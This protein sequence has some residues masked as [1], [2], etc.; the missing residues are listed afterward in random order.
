MLFSR[1]RRKKRSRA[2]AVDW[3]DP[4]YFASSNQAV[5]V[6]RVVW[7]LFVNPK[8][9]KTVPTKSGIV[10]MLLMGGLGSAAY[11]TAS[12]IL[13]LTVALLAAC[14]VLSGL[15]SWLNFKGTRWRLLPPNH[16]RAKEVAPIRVEVENQKK[17]LPTLSLW[18]HVQALEAEAKSRLPLE[19]RLDPG[20]HT[21][22]EWLFTPKTRG[23]ETI[24]ITGLQSQFPFGFL[25]KTI[26]QSIRRD[27]LI[28]PARIPYLFQPRAGVRAHREGITAKVAGS[29]TELINLRNYRPGDPP[30]NMHWKASARLG[31]ML[32]RE[33]SEEQ[34]ESYLLFI[35]TPSTTWK[36]GPQFEKLCSLVASLA[37][38][39]YTHNRLYGAAINDGEIRH[40][41]K[42]SDLHALLDE[43]TRLTPVEGYTPV[44]ELTGATTVTFVPAELDRVAILVGGVDAGGA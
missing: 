8:G 13:F 36:D 27:V 11:N 20:E 9:H 41:Q 24:E 4:G 6:A 43:L 19:E 17:V 14:L 30:R 32:I 28:W 23:E 37:E 12:N 42:V 21:E 25:R 2:P 10:L 22:L 7:H 44:E 39:L 18:F 33:M 34:R 31:R 29:G 40:I 16:L 26:G 35:E 38:D 5:N 3:A 15:M 1:R